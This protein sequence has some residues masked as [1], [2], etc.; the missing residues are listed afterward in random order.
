MQTTT[1]LFADKTKQITV[2]TG[3][4]ISAESGIPTFRGPEGYWTVG[5]KEYHPQEMA[6]RAMFDTHPYEVWKWYLYRLTVCSTAD[7]NPGH[8][9]LVE[10]E[11]LLQDRFTLVT[12]N[13][14]NLHLRAGN[15]FDRTFQIHGNV[16]Y[17]RCVDECQ[18]QL[19][20]LPTTILPRV[21]NQD[22]SDDDKA[23]LCCPDCGA[24]SRPHVLW[25]DECYDEHYFKFESAIRIAAKTDILIIAG[26]FGSTNLPNHI[27]NIVYQNQATIINIDIAQN[28]F[29]E[30]AINSVHGAFLNMSCSKGLA[31]ILAA[32]RKEYV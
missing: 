30:L 23:R 26:T 4:G 21:N 15:S 13:V 22:L 20:S 10:M 11:R 17:M 27:A 9:A 24:I 14:D 28:P 18:Q 16:F 29:A 7:P 25:F 32:I 1:S 3:A 2:L 31:S 19:Y 6:T 12:Q 8:H 5:A